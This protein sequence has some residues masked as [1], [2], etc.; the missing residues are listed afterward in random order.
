MRSAALILTLCLA[1]PAWAEPAKIVFGRATGPAAGAPAPH[2]GHARGCLAGAQPLPALG[3]GWQTMRPS[4]NRA[5]GHPEA[6]AFVRRLGAQ[7]RGLGWPRILI[8]DV[9]QPRGGPM[10]SG[11]SSHQTGLDV[12]VWLRRPGPEP[13]D[14]QRRETLPFLSMVRPDR[15][16]VNG[17]WTGG[18]AALLRAA[19]MDPA[20]ARIFVN[21]AIKRRLC[22]WAGVERGWLRKVRPWWGHDAHFHVRLACPADAPGCENQPPPP[23]GDGCDASLAWWFSEEAL[24]PPPPKTPPKP[25]PALR[26]ADLPPACRAVAGAP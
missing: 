13:L 11:H 24:N 17:R 22:D 10:T 1:A 8:G 16:D 9:S 5:W 14:A 7:A 19:A 12:D 21:A 6:V 3:A 18:H 25:R 4:R 15:R 2:G 26:L 23:P 20:V